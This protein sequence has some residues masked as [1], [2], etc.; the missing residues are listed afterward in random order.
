MNHYI[1]PRALLPLL[2]LAGLFLLTACGDDDTA[3]DDNPIVGTWVQR[4]GEGVT[5]HGTR[6]IIFS[7]D[8]AFQL[9]STDFEPFEKADGTGMSEVAKRV[10]TGHYVAADGKVRIH[11][12]KKAAYAADGRYLGSTTNPD[13]MD[14]RGAWRYGTYTISGNRLHL[15]MPDWQGYKPD[16][17]RK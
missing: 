8:G 9:T 5:A 10:Y 1:T 17:T 13:A 12:E 6:E 15:D 3:G 2:T 4:A 16:F 7:A 14:G 11:M